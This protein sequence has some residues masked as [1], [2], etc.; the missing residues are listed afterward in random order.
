MSERS[1]MTMGVLGAGIVG[2]T[3]ATGWAGAGHH[4]VL[5]SR[6]PE[7]ERIGATVAEIAREASGRVWAALPADAVPAA[8]LVVITVPGDGVPELIAVLGD[9][10]RGKPVIDTTNDLTPGAAAMDHVGALTEA[11]GIVYRALNSV[12]WEQ[13][14]NPRFGDVSS[15][16]PFAGPDGADRPLVERAITDLGFRAVYLGAGPQGLACVTALAQVWF[17]LA[18]SQGW[19][20]RLGMKFLTDPD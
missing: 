10:L 17:Q 16:M 9:T 5:G 6:E 14:A 2:R 7:S 11:G 8:D 13:M 20:R 1:D 4:I 12:G 19:G 15:D 3:L 18:F